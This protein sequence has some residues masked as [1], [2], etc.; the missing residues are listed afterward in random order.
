MFLAKKLSSGFRVWK[1][2]ETIFFCLWITLK[3]Q[4]QDLM[5]LCESHCNQT[6]EDFKPILKKETLQVQFHKWVFF[7]ESF[8]Q[9]A[10]QYQNLHNSI[11]SY[12]PYFV[13]LFKS[14]VLFCYFLCHISCGTNPPAIFLNLFLYEFIAF[15]HLCSFFALSLISM[16]I[17]SEF[18]KF[19]NVGIRLIF[20]DF[21]MNKNIVDTFV[22][23]FFFF[24]IRNHFNESLK[25]WYW[26]RA[27]FV[28]W[29]ICID[30]SFTY[31]AT[32][33]AYDPV[34]PSAFRFN[35][36]FHSV[37]VLDFFS[38]GDN[39]LKYSKLLVID[40]NSMEF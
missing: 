17:F 1:I 13:I 29:C 28:S 35:I 7:F 21:S 10:K 38:S 16:K 27:A 25:H 37:F 26:I 2:L 12:V 22:L 9:L 39:F 40:S 4:Q 34:L 30:I 18:L 23:V 32:A 6:S 20:V 14:I 3:Q 5:K 33:V 31:N 15:H 11:T 19:I 24:L 8:S 36:T